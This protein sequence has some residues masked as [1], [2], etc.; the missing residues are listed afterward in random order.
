LLSGDHDR[1]KS[2]LSHFFGDEEQLHF[3]Q[4]PAEK[5]HFIENLHEKKKNVM[6]VGDGLNDAGALKVADVGLSITEDTAH[7]SPAS[8][9]IMEASMFEHLPQFLRFSK[10]TIKVIHFSFLISLAYNFVGLFFA[11]QGDLSPLIAAILMP[12][13]SITIISFTTLATRWMAHKENLS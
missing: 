10:R 4:S 2:R 6:M 8:D 7:F 3:F 13:S 12:L 9:I 1:E 11:V 5:M